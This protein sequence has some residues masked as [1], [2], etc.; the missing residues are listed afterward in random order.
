[1]EVMVYNVINTYSIFFKDLEN[2]GVV[3]YFRNSICVTLFDKLSRGRPT[4]R[5]SSVYLQ[6]HSLLHN[7]LQTKSRKFA[8]NLKTVQKKFTKYQQNILRQL[9]A[10]ILEENENVLQSVLPNSP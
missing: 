10:K 6:F 1:M 7:I 3:N 4:D 8:L 2:L 9:S 5:A